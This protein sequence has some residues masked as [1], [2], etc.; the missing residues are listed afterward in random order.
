MTSCSKFAAF[1][2]VIVVTLLTAPAAADTA[3]IRFTVPVVCEAEGKRIDLDPGRYLPEPEWL[4]LDDRIRILQDTETRLTAEN[5]ELR[6][7]DP[8]PWK[9]ILGSTLVGIA[10]GAYAFRD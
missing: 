10:V 5:T 2:A 9:L 4:K 1:V 6:K 3:P 7:P 8:T